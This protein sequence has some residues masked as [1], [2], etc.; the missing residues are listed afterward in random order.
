MNLR[1]LKIKDAPLMLEWMHD[2]FVV[3]NMQTDFASKTLDDCKNF[4]IAAQ[5]TSEN[6]HK[7]IV[8]ENDIYMGTVSLKNIDAQSAEFAITVRRCAMGKGF[9]KFAMTEIIQL[10]FEKMNLN[11]VYWCVS[12]D[13]KRAVRF[14]DKNKYQRVQSKDIKVSSYSKELVNSLLWYVVKN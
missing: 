14:Y 5:D 7:A 12:P 4:I 13:N 1:E 6:I 10:G 9:S 2:P 3:E 11:T 8:D